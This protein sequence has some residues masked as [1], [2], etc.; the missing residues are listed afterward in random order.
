MPASF[1]RLFVAFLVATLPLRFAGFVLGR[2]SDGGALIDALSLALTE[3]AFPL[4]AWRIYELRRRERDGDPSR[5]LPVGFTLVAGLVVFTAGFTTFL[6]LPMM[7]LP[8]IAWEL[9]VVSAVVSLEWARPWATAGVLA[10]S[11][12]DLVVCVWGFVL[13]PDAWRNDFPL[14][15]FAVG[16]ALHGLRAVAVLAMLG[17][18]RSRG[19][20]ASTPAPAV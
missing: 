5:P 11:A 19:A 10:A 15:L 12:I 18:I 9:F 2:L 20:V 17:A 13:L 1:R 8:I 3:G 6:V 7:G 14:A 16:L 4:G